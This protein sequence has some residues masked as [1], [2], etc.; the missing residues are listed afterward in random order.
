MRLGE[1]AG[2]DNDAYDFGPLADLLAAFLG[3]GLFT[4]VI[5]PVDRLP[6]ERLDPVIPPDRLAYALAHRAW[7]A[8]EEKPSWA[9]WLPGPV[10]ANF[11]PSLRWLFETESSDFPPER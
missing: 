11:K 9:K 5:P 2:V 8:G 3:L 10:K 1:E 6:E 7:H 4:A